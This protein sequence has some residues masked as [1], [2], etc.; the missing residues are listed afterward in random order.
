MRA[1]PLKLLLNVAESEWRRDG[2]TPGSPRARPPVS[3]ER[4]NFY[5]ILHLQPDAPFEVVRRNFRTL[6]QKLGMHPDLGGDHASAAQLVEAYATLSDPALRESYDDELLAHYDLAMV[7]DGRPGG[8]RGRGGGHQKK[9][10]SNRRN[11]YRLLRVQRDAPQAILEAAL[12]DARKTQRL[13]RRVLDD[14]AIILG[15]PERRQIYDAARKRVGHARAAELALNPLADG[16]PEATHD[17]RIKS[18]CAFCKTPC[19]PSL[20]PKAPMRCCECESP[21]TTPPAA[22]QE[23][24]RRAVARMARS[25]PVRFYAY[26]PSTPETARLLDLSPTGLRMLTRRPIDPNECLKVEG[27]DFRAVGS[28]AHNARAGSTPSL[29]LRLL[30]VEFAEVR[31]SF[32]STRV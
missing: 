27:D 1:T 22:L 6:M 15:I 17:P 23:L 8:G 31:G 30:T 19:S 24:S 9:R 28:V 10:H 11:F 26:W 14:A 18:F 16:P 32:V 7:A 12:A 25:E 29:G 21:L 4:R 13:D 2:L 5:R 20:D 3:E